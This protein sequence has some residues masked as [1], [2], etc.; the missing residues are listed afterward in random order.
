M[1]AE[2][3]FN[4]FVGGLA[5]ISTLLSV[6]LYLHSYLP[7]PQMKAFDELFVETK[8]IYEKASAEGL[9]SPDMSRKAQARLRKY[10]SQGDD[11][12]AITYSTLTAFEILLSFFRGHSGKIIGL[13]S[14]LK[15]LR[16]ELLTASQE[17]RARREGQFNEEGS[18][19]IIDP[20]RYSVTGE[21]LNGR[22]NAGSPDNPRE[23]GPILASSR[24]VT[25]PCHST[26]C[27]CCTMQWFWGRT[28]VARSRAPL[29]DDVHQQPS[30]P[31]VEA[32]SRSSTMVEDP[33]PKDSSVRRPWL[34]LTRWTCS[35]EARPTCDDLE[36]RLA[37]SSIS[38]THDARSP[39]CRPRESNPDIVPTST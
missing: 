11:L 15:E 34:Y 27:L 18:I 37:V 32:R 20:V 7:G 28:R 38:G 29:P 21:C 19:P 10:E 16:G 8:T 35:G 31:D 5:L 24:T 3:T 36:A 4:F 25:A 23:P 22:N 1:A 30:L 9:L 14:N 17:E 26:S 33:I 12:R 39:T 2:N 13:S 6:L